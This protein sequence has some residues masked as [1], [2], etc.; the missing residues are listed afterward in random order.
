MMK[1]EIFEDNFTKNMIG[2]LFINLCSP[3]YTLEECLNNCNSERLKIK[4]EAY[5]IGNGEGPNTK[6]SKQTQID[7]LKEKIPE[8]F[9]EYL[10]ACEDHIIVTL[11]KAKSNKLVS[12]FNFDMCANGF[13]FGFK[14]EDDKNVFVVPKEIMDIFNELY[15][16]EFDKERKITLV[17]ETLQNYL[18]INGFM[19]IKEFKDIIYNFYKTDI[20][21]EDFNK[22][23]KKSKCEIIEDTYYSILPKKVYDEMFD[24][25]KEIKENNPYKRLSMHELLRYNGF[26]DMLFN[27]IAK[28][29]GTKKEKTNPKIVNEI[30][31]LFCLA[32]VD[33]NTVC[34]EIK[35]RYK[36]SNKIMD[37]LETTLELC[38][39]EL[40]IWGLNGMTCDEYIRNEIFE[41]FVI[42]EKPKDDT[43]LS[44]L[45]ALPKKAQNRIKKYYNTRTTSLKT[46]SDI[47]V[48]LLEEDI[49]EYDNID[50]EEFL[51]I[52][53]IEDCDMV[54]NEEILSGYVFLYDD[55]GT[56]KP[57]VPKEITDILELY[58]D[59]DEDDYDED[60]MMKIMMKKILK[61]QVMN[62]LW[63]V[64]SSNM[65]I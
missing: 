35:Y 23:I 30:I 15:T 34:T 17:T 43:L 54:A 11:K 59:E 8:R 13:M 51:D 1:E 46:L 9:T 31:T 42:K 19:P 26:L 37:K 63:K 60:S 12:D 32:G 2:E 49:E 21:E 47:I 10:N 25:L 39:P 29:I 7:Y 45:E 6:A 57:F 58:Y 27:E 18:L 3:K 61:R 56:I 41:G 33:T 22:A 24:D 20:E 5:K 53:E 52:N 38:R 4:Y 44:W 14:Q 28:I 40:K 55:N 48:A 36:L 50:I 16:P 65:Y 64:Y 62:K